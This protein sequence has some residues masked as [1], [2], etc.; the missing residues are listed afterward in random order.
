METIKHVVN[1][2]ASWW[3]PEHPEESAIVELLE[4]RGIEFTNITGWHNL[5]A[6]EI[7]LGAPQ[8]RARI[9][10]VDR[11]EMVRVSNQ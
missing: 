7:A 8:E 3:T 6:H 1:D 10:V 9:K 2:Q 5:D 11:D 4:S